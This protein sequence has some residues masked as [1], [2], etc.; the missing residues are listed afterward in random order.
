[1]FYQPSPCCRIGPAMKHARLIIV[2]LFLI[3][4]LPIL[5]HAGYVLPGDSLFVYK[6][7]GTNHCETDNGVDVVAMKHELTDAGITVISMRKGFDGREGIAVCGSPTGQINIYEISAPHL[8]MAQ[9]IG[10]KR[11]PESLI[12]H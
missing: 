6:L 3:I 12:N 9:K 10:F 7:D 11:L 4:N 5:V 2:I 1:M 8:K